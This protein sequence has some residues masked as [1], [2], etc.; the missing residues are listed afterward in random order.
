MQSSLTIEQKATNYETFR[1]IQLVQKLLHAIVVDLLERAEEHDQTKLESPEVEG[2]TEYTDKLAKCTYGSAEYHAFRNSLKPALDHH[3][4]RNRH[5]PE[6]YKDGVSDMSLLDVIEML[7]DWR[8][9]STRHD[10]GNIR[11]SIDINAERFGINPQLVKILH[12]T[13]DYLGW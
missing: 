12:N 2:F 3:Y 11:K 9:A 10:N 8:A 6:F 1:H 7:M 5:H 4:A 13:V